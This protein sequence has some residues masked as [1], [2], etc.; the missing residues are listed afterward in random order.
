MLKHDNIYIKKIRYFFRFK[1][2]DLN[3]SNFEFIVTFK[4]KQHIVKSPLFVVLSSVLPI[5]ICIQH[6]TPERSMLNAF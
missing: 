6:T 1:T 4:C 3:T 5:P 2:R